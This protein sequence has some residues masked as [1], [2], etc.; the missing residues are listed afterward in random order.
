M[1]R[2]EEILEFWFGG[3]DS[4]RQR[5][6]FAADPGFDDTCRARFLADYERAARGELEGWSDTAA[7][8]LALI[9]LL[10]QFPRNLFRGTAQAFATDQKALAIAKHAVTAGLDDILAPRQRAFIYMPFQHSEDLADQRESVR[11]FRELAAGD[12]EQA[13]FLEYAERHLEV[14]ARFGRFPHRNAVLGRASTPQ[15]SEFLASGGSPF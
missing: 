9:L 5:T 8:C 12:P 11:L 7:R 10:D 14:I 3:D 1:A 4:G 6:W 15:E 2:A 13:G